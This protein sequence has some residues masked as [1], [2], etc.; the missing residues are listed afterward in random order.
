MDLATPAFEAAVILGRLGVSEQAWNGGELT[1][2][3]PITG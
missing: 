1:A 2:R 3:S